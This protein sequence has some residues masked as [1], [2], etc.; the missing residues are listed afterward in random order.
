MKPLLPKILTSMVVY[1]YSQNDLKPL[2]NAKN[3][4]KV[5]RILRA[6]QDF[7]EVNNDLYDEMCHVYLLPALSKTDKY[8]KHTLDPG[9]SPS[10]IYDLA[11]ALQKDTSKHT[12]EYKMLQ[13]LKF[14]SLVSL[15]FSY[16]Y[17]EEHGKCIGFSERNFYKAKEVLDEFLE[18]PCAQKVEKE[19]ITFFHKHNSFGL[20][21]LEQE[22]G[23]GFES[24]PDIVNESMNFARDLYVKLVA[25]KRD[26]VS[27]PKEV[28]DSYRLI[29]LLTTI[30][31]IEMA[32]LC[33]SQKKTVQALALKDK[34]LSFFGKKYEYAFDIL[35]YL[36]AWQHSREK[37]KECFHVP[38]F[39]DAA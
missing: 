34:C 32:L 1:G 4:S 11:N 29:F 22:S 19:L 37:I 8:G 18:I 9:S 5:S 7:D 17:D 2:F 23:D 24:E 10:L 31:S 12:Q 26:K 3:V 21:M 36:Y 27:L 25:F 30:Q 38:Q 39:Q 28:E 33:D 13:H 16:E 6:E 20:R 35:M 14:T 15:T